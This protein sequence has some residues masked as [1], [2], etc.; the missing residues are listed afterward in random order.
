MQDSKQDVGV[1]KTERPDDRMIRVEDERTIGLFRN[2]APRR[3]E[4]E[5]AS[6]NE[7]LVSCQ[8]GLVANQAQ[9]NE[10]VTTLNVTVNALLDS[11]AELGTTR[12]ESDALQAQVLSLEQDLADTLETLRDA[13]ETQAQGLRSQ[14]RREGP[15]PGGE[16]AG[17]TSVRFSSRTIRP[18][19]SFPGSVTF[20]R[21]RDA[22]CLTTRR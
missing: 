4:A 15:V 5:I 17:V 9:L 21:P 3:L 16:E 19:G 11:E 13:F 20:R 8:A 14:R 6:T 2:C 22:T 10:T 18:S 12:A 1:G 7:D